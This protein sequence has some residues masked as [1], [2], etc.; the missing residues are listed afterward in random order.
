[1]KEE[2]WINPFSSVRRAP[3]SS[4]GGRGVL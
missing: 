3:D 1:M 4:S 2:K